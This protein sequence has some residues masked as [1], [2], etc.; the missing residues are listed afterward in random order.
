MFKGADRLP[1]DTLISCVRQPE[2]RDCPENSRE[3]ITLPLGVER[4]TDWRQS[5]RLSTSRVLWLVG[6]LD[7]CT[8]PLSRVSSDHDVFIQ[9]LEASDSGRLGCCLL[10]LHSVRLEPLE[11]F[12]G[13]LEE[14][15][16]S[17]VT[18]GTVTEDKWTQDPVAWLRI[19]GL[20]FPAKHEFGQQWMERHRAL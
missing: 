6:R 3:R 17:R 5:E 4:A 14:Q 1:K 15:E 11:T 16:P 2:M 10:R 12:E 8:G 13:A 7:R 9:R 18:L 19:G 20:L